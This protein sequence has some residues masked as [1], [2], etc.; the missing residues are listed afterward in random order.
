MEKHKEG[1]NYFFFPLLKK[2]GGGAEKKN[3]HGVLETAHSC[4]A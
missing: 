4:F 2:R 1:N 3:K